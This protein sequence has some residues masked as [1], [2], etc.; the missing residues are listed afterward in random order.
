[1]S[2]PANNLRD[3]SGAA[4]T[5]DISWS[6][7]NTYAIQFSHPGADS[8]GTLNK[9]M[10]HG[11]LNSGQNE[12]PN[13]SS[14]TLSEIS[15]ATYDIYVY[16]SADVADREGSVTDGTSTYYFRT[17]GGGVRRLWAVALSGL[18]HEQTQLAFQLRSSIT[19]PWKSSW[20]GG[21]PGDRE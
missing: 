11:Y 14:V 15:Y 8:D 19:N 1:M 10:L 12:P 9:E 20:R 18:P 17:L 3:S 21:C 7:L 16:F 6:S 2:N 13:S 4:T 5:I